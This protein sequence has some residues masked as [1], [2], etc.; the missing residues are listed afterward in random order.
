M[1]TVEEILRGK[2]ASGAELRRKAVWDKLSEALKAALRNV[3]CTPNSRE[4]Q[5]QTSGVCDQLVA[6]RS[7]E[8]RAIL[9]NKKTI[10]PFR[11]STRF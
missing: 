5:K 4:P 3:G 1:R 10:T 8:P 2:S 6:H 11:T 9:K 7:A